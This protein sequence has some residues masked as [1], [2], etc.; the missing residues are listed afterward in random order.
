[1]RQEMKSCE[2]TVEGEFIS[3]TAMEELGWSEHPDVIQSE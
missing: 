2:L 1:M 3:E